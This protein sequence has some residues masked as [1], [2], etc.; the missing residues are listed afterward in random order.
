MSLHCYWIYRLTDTQKYLLP[1]LQPPSQTQ[2]EADA[3]ALDAQ[4]ETIERQLKAIHADCQAT[5][6]AAEQQR[7]RVDGLVGDVDRLL[8]QVK[9]SDQKARDDLRE[10][11]QEVDVVRSM[12]PTVGHFNVLQAV[13]TT[14]EYRCWR[15]T[16]RIQM[17]PYLSCSR[18]SNRSRRLYLART[19]DR[20]DHFPVP[21]CLDLRGDQPS[22]HGNFQCRS[23]VQPPLLA[24]SKHKAVKKL[25]LLA[26]S[27]N[28]YIIALYY[29]YF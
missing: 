29:Y 11:R 23:P 16:R 24:R 21:H 8:Q 6:Q 17:R 2:Y 12:V 13:L 7:D 15:R 18:S 26:A 27:S 28:Y 19:R 22:R 4:F 14:L 20:E 5:R 1:H 9:E 10:I 3:A 25:P